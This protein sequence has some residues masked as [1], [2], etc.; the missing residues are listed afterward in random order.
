MMVAGLD[1]YTAG[2]LAVPPIAMVSYLIQKY[3]VFRAR[4]PRRS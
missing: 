1:A 3:L 2:A 4:E